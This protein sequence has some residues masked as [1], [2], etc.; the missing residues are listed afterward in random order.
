M[1]FLWTA[2]YNASGAAGAIKD[3]GTGRQAAVEGLSSV[4]GTLEACHFSATGTGVVLIVD[5]PDQASATAA[6]FTVQAS[7]AVSV[8][9]STALLTA[10]EL[11]AAMKLSPVYTAPGA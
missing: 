2:E 6:L 7:G 8:V 5:A 9:N 4:G 10:A 11:D 1:K 3:G